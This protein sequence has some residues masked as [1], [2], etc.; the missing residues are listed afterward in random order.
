MQQV[1]LES[2]SAGKTSFI[3]GMFVVFVPILEYFTPGFGIQLNL[4][5]WIAAL[6]SLAG[7][8]LLSGCA[9]EHVRLKND[10]VSFSNVWLV[11][12]GL[13]RRCDRLG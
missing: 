7:L 12:L 8:Y 10:T 6:V 2:V 4:Q 13:L 1:G 9:E 11:G 3:T 5:R